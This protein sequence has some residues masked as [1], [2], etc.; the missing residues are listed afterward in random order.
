[1]KRI[2]DNRRYDTDTATE[3]A[4]W[5]NGLGRSDCSNCTETLYR[6]SKGNWFLVGEG[7]GDSR[8]AVPYGNG[9]LGGEAIRPL[10]PEDAKEWLED[11]E[12]VDALEE[13]FSAE[14][15]DA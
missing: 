1:M 8:Y 2:I 13:H 11:H 3:I 4:E 6:T 12:K 9:R 5:S 7:G 10:T 14:I 15:E